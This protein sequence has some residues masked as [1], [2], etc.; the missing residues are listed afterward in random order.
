MTAE[1]DL[2]RILDADTTLAGLVDTRIYQDVIPQADELPA[3]VFSRTGTEPVQT[4]HGPA[5]GAFAALQVQIW[6]RTRASAEAVAAAVVAA[7]N[8]SGE[9]YVARGALYDEETKSHGIAVDVS[10]FET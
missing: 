7:L 6:A 10:I 3:V 4:I 8:A 2:Y 1:T 9:S 5:V